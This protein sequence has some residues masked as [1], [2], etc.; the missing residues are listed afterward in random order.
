MEESQLSEEMMKLSLEPPLNSTR[1][2]FDLEEP[3]VSEIQAARE[4][5]RRLRKSS[6]QDSVRNRNMNN[7]E[8][9][10]S[11]G[12]EQAQ[13]KRDLL[14]TSYLT[15]P[16]QLS[17]ISSIVES[18]NTNEDGKCILL[19]DGPFVRISNLIPF[20]RVRRGWK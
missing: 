4:Q 11:S 18:M 8:S 16:S 9:L 15:T 13:S 12:N 5:L 6:G 20:Q 14:E 1:V 19:I 2:E 3:E 7:T 10:E 17:E